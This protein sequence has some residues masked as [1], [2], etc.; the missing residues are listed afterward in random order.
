MHPCIFLKAFA[1]NVV[2][3]S[4]AQAMKQRVT[5]DSQGLKVIADLYI[6][7]NAPAGVLPAIVVSHPASGVKEQ[8]A[9]LYGRL[10]S[11]K[12]FITI[13]PDGAYNGESEGFP[14]G[15]EDPSQRVEDIKNAISF[16]SRHDRVDPNRIGLFGVCA[17]GGY[18]IAAAATDSRIKAAATVSGVDVGPFFR[19]GYNGK[20]D[21]SVHISN[22][23][24]AATARTAVVAVQDIGGFPIFPPNETAARAL[25]QYAYEGWEYY[26]TA[27][28]FHPRS[29]KVMPWS[30]IDKISGFDGFSFAARISPKP[31]LMIVGTNADTKWLSERAFNNAKQPKE[32]FW[33]PG[34]SHVDLYDKD[35]YVTPAVARLGEYFRQWLTT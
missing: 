22:L 5:F 20:Q 27:R 19:N 17:S 25:G 32:L 7:D 13:V 35:P 11:D 4:T 8:T 12:G 33:I 24:S 1:L 30:S 14:R 23:Q 28:A 2:F 10:L 18:V 15:L 6:P 9:G 16:L 21:P 26:N 29:A 31:L 3:E 34:A